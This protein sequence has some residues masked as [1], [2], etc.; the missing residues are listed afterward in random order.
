MLW[1]VLLIGELVV[2][3]DHHAVVGRQASS[4][5][6]S[7]VILLVPVEDLY[8]AIERRV[9][10]EVGVPERA[11]SRLTGV[12]GRGWLLWLWFRSRRLGLLLLLPLSQ[13]LLL[14]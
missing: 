10:D 11:S 8:A 1:I 13:L 6:R 3:S 4:L 5:P 9:A 2:A 7:I 14:P 12:G